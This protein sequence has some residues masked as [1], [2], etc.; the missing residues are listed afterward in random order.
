MESLH[1]IQYH[2]SSCSRL[3]GLSLLAQC[4]VAFGSLNNDKRG[5]SQ[6]ADHLNTVLSTTEPPERESSGPAQLNF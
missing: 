2:P 6:S 5:Q 4:E 1:K 3:I